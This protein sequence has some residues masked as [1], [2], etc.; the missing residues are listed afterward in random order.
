MK[1]FAIRYLG[2]EMSSAI[3]GP[4]DPREVGAVTLFEDADCSG[5]SARFYWDPESL[6]NGTFYNQ[7]DLKY[8]GMRD[9]TLSSVMVPKGYTVELYRHAGFYG[10][11]NV[12]EGAYKDYG[13]EEMV[14]QRTSQDLLSS[15]IV[16]RQPQGIANAYWQSI[17]TTESQ[18][19]TY[20]V[21]LSY[22][23]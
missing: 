11:S 8:A 3:L 16:K 15:L 21:G 17:T 20:H 23:D 2:N 22:E 4:Y 14:C 6:E 13:S 9:N 1:N 19:I 7:E 12:I 5:A 10:E 18:E